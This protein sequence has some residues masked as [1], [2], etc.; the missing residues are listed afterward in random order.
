M[1]LKTSNSYRRKNFLL[2]GENSFAKMAITAN[3][4]P[5]KLIGMPSQ[6]PFLYNN[7]NPTKKMIKAAANRIKSA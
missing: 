7:T 3:R 2:Q 6:E 4:I 1:P 5:D